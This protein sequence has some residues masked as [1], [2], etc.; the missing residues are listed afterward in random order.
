MALM[1]TP[2]LLMG[3]NTIPGVQIPKEV[4][5][6]I[7]ET[8]D[9]CR[10]FGLDFY[11][12]IIEFLT[13]DEISEIAAYGGFPVRYPHWQWGE[14]YEELSRGYE[15]HQ[16]RIFEMVVNCCGLETRVATTKGTKLAGE[17]SVG[18]VVLGPRGT[19]KVTY[20]KR[21]PTSRV[22]R[23]KLH[24]FASDTVC[25]PEHKWKCVRGGKEVWV[26]AKDLEVGDMVLAGGRY[27]DF[28]GVAADLPWSPDD[29]IEQTEKNV[30]H[31]LKPISPPS[32]MTLELAELMGVL[33]GDGSIG[34]RLA[35]RQ[36][37]V[38][39][40]KPQREYQL[41]VA[42][43]L[44]NVFGSE[45]SIYE[46]KNSVNIVSFSSKFAVDFV[47]KAGLK[48]GCTYRT[49]RVPWSIWKSSNEY[50]AVFL[51]GLFDTDGYVGK[52]LS[53]SCFSN[54]F[55]ED[56]QQLL[57]EMGI[58]S[59]FKRVENKHNSIVYLSIKGKHNIDRFA[60]YIGFSVGY[61]LEALNA[62]VSRSGRSGKGYVL[63][64]FASRVV[65]RIKNVE[66][67]PD[68]MY[69]YG[70]RVG[71]LGATVNSFYGALKKCV[72]EGYEEFT[73]LLELASTP[74]YKVEAVEEV[75][76]QETVDIALDNDDHD[77]LANGLWSH[78][79]NPCYI[80]CLD[81]NTVTDHITVIAHATGHNHFFKN[82]VFFEKTSQ[83]MI[84]ELAN[85][86]S[87]IRRY[88]AEWGKE[89][90]GR[91]ID[92]ILSVETLI[93]PASAW[94]KRRIKE[95]LRRT[96][97][98]YHHPRRLKV[99]HDYMDEWINPP[100][101]VEEEN[102][103]IRIEEIKKN[104]S[105][106][107]KPDKNVFGFLKDHAPLKPWQ[108]DI[109]AML[110]EEAMYFA[111][112]RQTKVIN[113]GFASAVD[114]Q[115]MARYGFAYDEGIFDY[116]KH[117]AGVLGGKTSMNPYK[118][119]YLL[120]LDIEERWNKGRFGKEY[121]EC[122]DTK[123]KEAWDKKLGLGHEKVFEVV[124]FY[125]D[126]T[127]ISEFF[128]QEF[129]DKYQFYHWQRFPDGTYKIMDR[130]AKRIKQMLMMKH[131]NGGLPE[132]F[133]A[134]PNYQGK[135]I[136]LMEHKWDGRML[137]PQQTRD[138]LKAV[139]YLWAGPAAL[140]TKDKDAREIIYYCEDGNVETRLR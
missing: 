131:I 16:F 35:A 69:A 126:V 91:F 31:C 30:R 108:Q 138:T 129:C 96:K 53:M 36:L 46:Q 56:I 134:D 60:K 37:A 32:K 107:G 119:G 50:R 24:E 38:S 12:T 28:L 44:K 2:S 123:I 66:D 90:V 17:V 7:P 132:I 106:F 84:N 114:S 139:N 47:D 64:G 112:Q 85:H 137:H 27:E 93:D 140:V 26:E 73:D 81:S 117:K 86:G 122:E 133:L 89:N 82:N 99:D 97:R 103:R 94:A 70:N 48:K 110:Y 75:E 22:V 77:F 78:N 14:Q 58:R 68:W 13:Y 62:L 101:W 11:D 128:T 74:A 113:E 127:L 120:L 57:L 83:N 80:Y 42:G 23:I 51:R 39:V 6:R 76:K 15:H 34:V 29:V 43:L 52:T 115:I 59:K 21:Q 116:A 109:M 49:K 63:P 8:L 105:I 3:N 95:P 33:V 4:L 19:R 1:Q 18:D 87:R 54:D 61:K 102:E 88:M 92:K 9:A 111:P 65:E 100:K 55:A 72:S 10:K 130:D 45:A 20:V 104:L 25:T 40:H 5:D 121:D 41:K 124:D 118:L 79:T 67:V 125:D 135:R 98:E 136:F 71:R